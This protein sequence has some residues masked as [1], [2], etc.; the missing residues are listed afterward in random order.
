MVAVLYM[1]QAVQATK[2]RV[3]LDQIFIGLAV[4]VVVHMVAPPTTQV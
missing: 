1:V 4:A 2:I 3:L